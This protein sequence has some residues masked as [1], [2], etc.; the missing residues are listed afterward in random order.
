MNLAQHAEAAG[1]MDKVRAQGLS[2]EGQTMWRFLL[3][4]CPPFDWLQCG[5]M[6]LDPQVREE[7]MSRPFDANECCNDADCTAKFVACFDAPADAL[8]D[9]RIIR[10]LS[11][12]LWVF[13]FTNLSIER[14]LA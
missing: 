3:F 11:T 4:E 10:G 13:R 7:H 9:K 5:N 2:F 6:S 12:V 8:K 14:L 1:L